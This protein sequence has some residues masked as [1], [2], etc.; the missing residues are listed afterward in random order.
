MFE[1][2]GFVTKVDFGDSDQVVYGAVE[3]WSKEKPWTKETT[4]WVNP[5]AIS[6]DGT[7]DD[8][9]L[10]MGFRPLDEPYRKFIMPHY[11]YDEEID[12]SFKSEALA[13]GEVGKAIKAQNEAKQKAAE[14]E[15]K[16]VVEKAAAE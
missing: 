2:S 12:D 3:P 14:E 5:L 16:R 8:Q 13:E 4:G 7:D 11:R 9:I 1:E 10:D 15:A 6:D